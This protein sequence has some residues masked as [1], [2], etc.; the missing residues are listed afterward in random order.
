MT[1]KD[2]QMQEQYQALFEKLFTCIFK[3][4][5]EIIENSPDQKI[6]VKKLSKQFEILKPVAAL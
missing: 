2:Y 5:Q 3:I 6:I 4:V 1:A